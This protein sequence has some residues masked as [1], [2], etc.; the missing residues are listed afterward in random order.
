MDG[1]QVAVLVAIIVVILLAIH[2][3][4]GALRA[5]R[6]RRGVRRREPH[7]VVESAAVVG[8]VGGSMLAGDDQDHAPGHGWDP[9]GIADPGGGGGFGG[10]FGGDGGAGGGD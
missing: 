3:G 1:S 4:R 5:E 7:G 10:G 8:L 2:A 6:G 9:S